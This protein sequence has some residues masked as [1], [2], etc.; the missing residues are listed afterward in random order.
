LK[1]YRKDGSEGTTRQ[2]IAA[3]SNQGV[4]GMTLLDIGG[5]VGG[6]QH[7]FLDQGAVKATHVD[8]ST[9]YVQAAQDE[10][11]RRE[12][13]QRITFLQGDFVDLA[14]NIPPA[15]IV[16]LDRVVCCY[17]DMQ[18]LVRLSAEKAGKMYG[19]VIPRDLWPIRVFLPIANFFLSLTGTPFRIFIHRTEQVDQILR[20]EG[21][22][23]DFYEKAG[24][25]QILV[26]NR[27]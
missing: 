27:N 13:D 23:P 20:E 22:K 7:A 2:L 10:A 17:D 11:I 8:A 24:F 3:I 19:L 25:W 26:Y 5:G 6:I 4:E 1:R 16:T 18:A 15:D 12:I 21:L 9:A 14:E